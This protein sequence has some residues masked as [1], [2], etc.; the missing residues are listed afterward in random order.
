MKILLTGANGFV[1]AG[2]TGRLIAEQKHIV[3]GA[4]RGESVGLPPSLERVEVGPIGP[5]TNWRPALRGVD[6]V[7]HLAAR[8]H[9]PSAT[10]TSALAVSRLVNVDATAGLARQAAAAGAKRFVFLSSV[11]VNGEGGRFSENDPPLP[12]DAYAISKFEAEVALRAIAEESGMEVVIIRPP[13]VYGPGVKANFLTL[14]RLVSSGVP[15]PFGAVENSRSLIALAN[16][17]DFILTCVEHPDAANETFL[18]SDNEDLSTPELIR[19]MA[20]AMGCP[21]RLLPVPPSL[22]FM[23]ARLLGKRSMA[24]RLLGD[25]QVDVSKSRQ[26]LGWEPSITVDEGLDLVVKSL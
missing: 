16:L 9:L 17:V 26:M 8:V 2:L 6:T 10:N 14:M 1:G 23:G 25:L 3:V 15:L 20:R 21:A 11:K 7:V 24:Q 4:V 18:I 22:L 13:L 12:R 5:L 19:R